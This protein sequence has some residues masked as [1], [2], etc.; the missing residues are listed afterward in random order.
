MCEANLGQADK[1][2]ADFGTFLRV[3]PNASID[4]ATYSK[5]A[6]AAFEDAQKAAQAVG[7][8]APS[9]INAYKDFQPPAKA[10]SHP[11]EW[12]AKGPVQWILT[13]DEKQAWARVTDG[14]QRDEFVEKFWLSRDPTPGTEDNGFRATFE[15]RVAFADAYFAD[16]NEK[17]GSM[18]DRGMVFVLLGPPTY[19][20]R[21]PLRTGE[22]ASEDAGMSTL[23]SQEAAVAQKNLKASGGKSVTSGKL[24]ALASRSGGDGKTA[25]DAA[26]NYQEV[27][28]YRKELLPK[29][30]SYHQVDVTFVTRQGYGVNVLQRESDTVTTLEAAK[31]S[32]PPVTTQ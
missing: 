1:A 21:K 13:S 4:S 17:P 11:D 23:G 31:K 15:K 16:D 19:G 5:K 8:G 9:L 2:R 10:I 28:H 7:T 30:V 18:T 32:Q 6:V 26:G 20:G 24:A 14:N 3:Q 12:W 27:W 22:D 25:P 29:G